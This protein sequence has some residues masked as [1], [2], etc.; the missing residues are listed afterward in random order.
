MNQVLGS[1]S[2]AAGA[3]LAFLPGG[4]ALCKKRVK[5]KIVLSVGWSFISW[6]VLILFV[7][8]RFGKRFIGEQLLIPQPEVSAGP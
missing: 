2:K 3:E 8:D 4:N 5:G 6:L 7:T 1:C